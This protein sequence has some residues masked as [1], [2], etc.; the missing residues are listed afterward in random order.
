MS[1]PAQV[2]ANRANSQKSTGPT[3]GPGRKTSSRNS[4]TFGISKTGGLFFFLPLEHEEDFIALEFKFISEHKPQTITES[5]IVRRMV[6]SEWL[7]N[8][9]LCLQMRC[10]DSE[11]GMI[12]DEKQL[13]LLLRY[14]SM[15]ERAF[16]KAVNELQKLRKEKKKEEIGFVSQTRA[17]AVHAMKEEAFEM[18]KQQFE[19]K[20]SR[21]A[22]PAQP[23]TKPTAAESRLESLEMAA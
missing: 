20:K 19:M 6:E 17:A 16:Y 9:A 8:R 22:Q 5:V 13:A 14:E 7:R 18:K 12:G 3:S 11:T 21:S 2:Q 15:H 23:E 1:T 4:S 10:Y